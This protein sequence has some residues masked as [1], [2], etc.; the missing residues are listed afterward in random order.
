MDLIQTVTV[1]AGGAAS[2]EFGASGTLPQ[3]FTDLYLVTSLR[4][5]R[6]SPDTEDS[7]K[8]E[9]NNVTTGYNGRWLRGDGANTNSNT[10][11][12]AFFLQNQ[13]AGGTTSNIF[14]NANVYVP[15][16]TSSNNK[17]LSVDTVNE[18][19]GTTA[20]AL[21]VAG[22]WSNTA[23]ITSVKLTPN[24]GTGFLQYSSASLYGILKVSDG[25]TTV[26]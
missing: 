18:N 12:T 13:N 17:C 8:I 23:A 25:T 20:W 14:S 15:N 26:S 4:S 7:V 5:N 9:F 10:F 22:L 24:V 3:T 16:Y 19:N 6:S 2:I 11:S 21:I 1:G